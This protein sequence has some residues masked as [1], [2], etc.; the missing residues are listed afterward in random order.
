[1]T[2]RYNVYFNGNEAFQK[3]VKRIE[4][5][6]Q[7]DYS[8]ILPLFPYSVHSNLGKS[9]KEMDYAIEK[10]KKLIKKHS[11]RSK[12]KFKS[13]RSNDKAYVE[14]FR[15][16]EFNSMVKDAY[17]LMGKAHFYKGEFLESIGI[18]NYI[19][20][21]FSTQEVR[22]EAEL[23]M[24]SAYTEMGWYYE[25][26]DILKKANDDN[27]PIRLSGE[28]AAISADLAL[29]REQYKDAIP[30]LKEAIAE[31]KDKKIK[32]RYLYILAQLYQ[33]SENFENAV[34]TYN[35]VLKM[36]PPYEMEFNARIRLTEVFQGKGNAEGIKKELRKMIRDEKNQEYLDQIYYAIAN[37][38]LSQNNVEAAIENY[39]LSV[40]NSTKNNV[41]KGL[42]QLTLANI[43]FDRGEYR[44]A[45]PHYAGAATAFGDEY[46]G[47]RN[48]RNLANVLNQMAEYFEV[49][50]YQDSMQMVASLT[51]QQQN[52]LIDGIIEKVKAD[53]KRAAE[54][55]A[56]GE[57]ILNL[58]GQSD[59]YFYN[60][61]LVQR[62]REEFQ[63]IWGNRKLE[64]N[65]RRSVKMDTGFGNMAQDQ[66]T[67]E[68]TAQ[69]MDNK[70]REFYL[71]NIPSSEQEIK[72]SNN[73]IAM[74]LFGL[75]EVFRVNLNDYDKAIDYYNQLISKFPK[76]EKVLDAYFGLYQCYE[77][78]D[79]VAQAEV[80]KQKIIDEFPN[81]R[82]ATILSDPDYMKKLE[83]AKQEQ[84]SLYEASYKAYMDGDFNAVTYNYRQIIEKYPDTELKPNF[85]FLNA[86]ITGSNQD[87]AEVFRKQLTELR[88]QYPEERVSEQAKNIL[89][90]LDA[91]KK[92]SGTGATPGSLL[93]KRDELLEQLGMEAFVD[94]TAVLNETGE[95]SLYTYDE[96]ALY[97]F[98]MLIPS[99]RVNENQFLYEVARF[100]FTKFLIKDFDLSW[101]SYN[102]DT[103]ILIING[104]N[105][106][107]ESLWYQ[108]T[109]I[110][111]QSLYEILSA[112]PYERMVISD[113]NF[114]ALV[115]TRDLEEYER[116]YDRFIKP[117][118][119]TIQDP[120]KKDEPDNEPPGKALNN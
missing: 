69:V 2:S 65:W 60:P 72:A 66:D 88:T 92:L 53:E 61:Q 17:M 111:D 109:F 44:L 94:T 40:E 10:A 90:Q 18:F 24:A 8:Q 103:T 93:K 87:S 41:Q 81:S 116:F 80:Y 50:E 63:R 9:D 37:L 48:I 75:G 114:R 33:K 76:H 45:Q 22:Y 25:A 97:Y 56:K 42:S 28:F 77:K 43:Y 35:Q 38:E 73:K 34:A 99:G 101:L 12:P 89:A 74:A 30:Y 110:L 11:I 62:G 23:W 108:R 31:Q 119:G 52:V 113:R 117:K 71:Q 78:K 57:S 36:S 105:G 3:G 107:D 106:L 102:Q 46:P 15:Q 85:M 49:I 19:R 21:H 96:D 118:E 67:E 59:W 98:V 82:Y 13:T 95:R 51:P 115:T 1:M 64:D 91:G 54:A 6:L 104:F 39:E 7:D 86:L 5:G 83:L 79:D 20:R 16:E 112:I 70:T 120:F 84:D 100:N 26:E 27:F 29:K 4:D 58:P 32:R 68:D 55:A 47:V 14:W